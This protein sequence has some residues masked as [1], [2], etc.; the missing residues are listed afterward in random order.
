MSCSLPP[1]FPSSTQQQLAASYLRA[2]KNPGAA[3]LAAHVRELWL[4]FSWSVQKN[5]ERILDAGVGERR[6][7]LLWTC[8]FGGGVSPP[9]SRVFFC[10]L[11][12]TTSCS[13]WE[14]SQIF[15][16][17]WCSDN[18]LKSC[19][20]WVFFFLL[21]FIF[22]LLQVSKRILRCTDKKNTKMKTFFF[23]F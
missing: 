10:Q 9:L 3:S 14:F 13:H 8:L 4:E 5:L 22:F 12:S 7:Q 21:G 18:S 2:E 19:V 1:P 6:S 15:F 17:T 16:T 11:Q 23:M 20:F